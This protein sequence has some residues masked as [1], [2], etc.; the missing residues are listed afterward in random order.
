MLTFHNAS[1]GINTA[2]TVLSIFMIG[3]LCHAN[4]AMG[5][6]IE[7]LQVGEVANVP[8][9]TPRIFIATAEKDS[10]KTMVRVSVP[11]T[12]S[13]LK[14]SRETYHRDY[15]RVWK[16]TDPIEL[17]KDVRAYLPSGEKIDDAAVLKSLEK[18]EAVACFLRLHK[19]DPEQPDPF[20]SSVFR[21]NV[22][23]LVWDSEKYFPE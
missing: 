23:I 22:I 21:K 2:F 15:V 20:Y 19:N 11:V 1:R 5:Q 9:I 18:P 10:G 13:V 8:T 12:R 4:K 6:M 3:S 17:G 16:E 7:G 14:S